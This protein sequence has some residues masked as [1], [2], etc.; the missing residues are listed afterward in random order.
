LNVHAY[1]QLPTLTQDVK[2][3]GVFW[4]GSVGIGSNLS[5]TVADALLGFAVGNILAILGG[6]L[7]AQSKY[8][9]WTFFPLAIL[10][11]TIP[12]IVIAS[13]FSILWR[14][15]LP[16][17]VPYLFS[18]FKITS[19]LCFVGAIVGEWMLATS[20]IGG[21]FDTYSFD[22]RYDAVWACVIV[23]SLC[24]LSFFALVV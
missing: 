23:V 22:K 13:R 2:A 15:R 7:F 3:L 17:A 24:S 1:E 5:V 18:S 20:G 10:V 14:L 11:Q 16:S 6:I 4:P 8:I 21:L 19:T 9:E 12:I